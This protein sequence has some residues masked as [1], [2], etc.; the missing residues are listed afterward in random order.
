MDWYVPTRQNLDAAASL[1][2][3][4]LVKSLADLSTMLSSLASNTRSS[5]NDSIKKIEESMLSYLSLIAHALVGSADVL[6]DDNAEQTDKDAG[7]DTDDRKWVLPSTGRT[8]LDTSAYASKTFG[9]IRMQVLKFVLDMNDMI[10]SAP[11]DSLLSTLNTSK[12]VRSKL[13]SIFKLIILRR[14]ATLKDVGNKKKMYA[15]SKRNDRSALAKYMQN[16][17]ISVGKYRDQGTPSESNGMFKSRD[18][19]RGHDI[20]SFDIRERARLQFAVIKN[21]FS[22]AIIRLS[23]NSKSYKLNGDLYL[24]GLAKLV[25]LCGHNYDDIRN[26]AISS[27][28]SVAN[29][30]GWKL[31]EFVQP[32]LLSICT[33][34]T[35]YASAAGALTIIS[36]PFVMKKIAGRWDLTELF[37]RCVEG[38]LSMMFSIDESDK[39]EILLNKLTSAFCAYVSHF[40]HRPLHLSGDNGNSVEANLFSDSCFKDDNMS[41]MGMRHASFASYVILHLIG[42]DDIE[43]PVGIVKWAINLVTTSMGEPTQIIALA[44]LTKLVY[45]GAFCRSTLGESVFIEL[46][47]SFSKMPWVPF[48]SGLAR[49]HPKS[50]S[51]SQPQWSPG[52]DTILRS[53]TYLSMCLPRSAFSSTSDVNMYSAFF[54]REHAA[55]FM[56][57][58][59]ISGTGIVVLIVE[60][61][62]LALQAISSTN[63]QE[64][65]ELNSVCAE[66]FSGV[67]RAIY[68]PKDQQIFTD[69]EVSELERVVLKFLTDSI[70]SISLDYCREYAD[71]IAFGF[72]M[73][74]ETDSLI[75]VSILKSLEHS[76]AF[77][78]SDISTTT[79]EEGFSRQSKLLVLIGALLNADICNCSIVNRETSAVA[80]ELL[81]LFSRESIDIVSPF[82]TSRDEI[83]LIVALL[84]E[85]NSVV[86]TDMTSILAK[87]HSSYFVD[88]GSIVAI[89]EKIKLKQK[90]AALT[91]ASIVSYFFKVTSSHRILHVLPSLL[92]IVLDGCSHEEVEVAK[93]CHEACILAFQGVSISRRLS[94]TGIDSQISGHLPLLQATLFSVALHSSLHVRETV[95]LCAAVLLVKQWHY[96]DVNERKAFRDV[97]NKGLLDAKPEVQNIAKVG[98]TSYLLVKPVSELN[99]LAAAYA[100]NCSV[101]AERERQRRRNAGGVP[102]SVSVEHTTT[103]MMTACMILAFPYDVPEY[104]PVL[105]VNLA[106]HASVASLKDTVMRTIQEFKRTHQ[107]RWEE[108]KTKFT[109][110]ELEDLQ[111]ASAMSYYS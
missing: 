99:A 94:S 83:G 82:R 8:H 96:M 15:A 67:C 32:L 74:V 29:R 58:L 78:E 31:M 1:L 23:L 38:S 37:L 102:E 89:S 98:M 54:K 66:F 26:Q 27:F 44:A 70:S 35:S 16:S 43:I 24:R 13:L 50:E 51:D 85:Q 46:Q 25:Q 71:A 49:D 107:D 20:S 61:I 64:A 92:R 55:I 88:Q 21:E 60:Q 86:V 101:L 2:E 48:I 110:E 39:R 41:S 108:F 93:I 12:H 76:L 103:V 57:I 45:M 47:K 6:G 111:G 4:A 33:Q 95:Q 79:G 77:V 9:E 36:L 52:I 73:P 53:A 17:L 81:S 40:H 42:H 22:S 59:R 65:K 91:A 19:W 87:L 104:I 72:A 97:F 100:K 30:F 90:N 56:S 80:T 62:I 75:L 3:F 10:D 18:F 69:E 34:G 7:L 68:V 109:R 11:A 5:E 63:E 28:T 14:S 84:T 105:L 106:R